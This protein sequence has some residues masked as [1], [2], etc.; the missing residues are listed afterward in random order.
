MI[1]SQTTDDKR[2]YLYSGGKSLRVLCPQPLLSQWERVSEKL[3]AHLTACREAKVDASCELSEFIPGKL[4]EDFS[5]IKNQITSH[6]ITT[7]PKPGN[8]DFLVELAQ[9]IQSIRAREI[10]LNLDAL[11]PHLIS[12]HARATYKKLK[13]ARRVV[14][15][16]AF[17]T[18][19]GR[20]TTKKNSFPILTLNKQFRCAIE[21]NNDYFLELDFNAAELRTLLALSGKE[22]PDGD[23]HDWNAEHVYRGT[24]TRD[25]AKK[26]IFAWLYNPESKDRLSSCT[27]D[28]EDV[29]KEHYDGQRVSTFFGRSI[30]SDDHHALNYIV[31]STAS[32]LLLKRAVEIDKILKGKK[33][34]IAFTLHDSLIIDFA[35]EDK[36]WLK[37]IVD[38]FR[39]TDLG[40]FVVN[41]SVGKNFGSMEKLRV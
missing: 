40:R 18:K 35:E 13:A 10:N 7:Y 24:V 9:V 29:V 12:V 14:D 37:Q 33:S 27:Y 31:Q 5:E 4:L 11:K 2:A 25:E 38:T 23:L 30:L 36:G 41:V 17:K 22:Q 21:P 3:K 19:T 28:R 34:Y 16:D 39:D 6:V 1:L 20:L 32:D 26:R 8:Y 15:Y